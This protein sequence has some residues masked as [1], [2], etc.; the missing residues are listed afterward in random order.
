MPTPHSVVLT[1]AKTGPDR[2]VAGTVTNVEE[3]HLDL[4]NKRLTINVDTQATASNPANAAEDI[5]EYDLSLNTSITV[6][7]TAGAYTVTF[8]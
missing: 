8:A 6:A 5:R 7:I 4:V 1:T 3:I 2:A